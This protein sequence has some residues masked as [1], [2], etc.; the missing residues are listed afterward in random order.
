MNDVV[1]IDDEVQAGMGRT[2]K[3]FALNNF[4]DSAHNV[5][6]SMAKGLHVSSVLIEKGMDYKE[7]G[8][9]STTT[10]YGRLPDIAVGYAKLEAILDN[11]DSL[12][13]NAVKM[14]DY[15]KKELKKINDGSMTRIDGLGLMLVT[16]F[17]SPKV[18]N[19]VFTGLVERGLLPLT[20]G[21]KG[22]RWLPPLDVRKQELDYA[23]ETLKQVLKTL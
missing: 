5:V 18:R 23:A 22:I 15:F 1:Y 14:G 20:V 2:G 9:A 17:E 13:Q 10:G 7:M 19:D 16:D 21:V 6:M 11:G 12:M 8:R 4:V 3:F